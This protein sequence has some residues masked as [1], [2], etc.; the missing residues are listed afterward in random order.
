VEAPPAEA[1]QVPMEPMQA[2]APPEPELSPEE[3]KLKGNEL[4][5]AGRHPEAV[6][7][8]SKAVAADPSSHVFL[9]NRCAANAAMGNWELVQQDATKC[10]EVAQ[11]PFPKGHIHLA[12]ACLRLKDW[13]AGAVAVTAG[14][15]A[16]PEDKELLQLQADLLEGAVTAAKDGQVC[17]GPGVEVLIGLCKSNGND[18]YKAKLY[19]HAVDHY[20]KAI[21]LADK[22]SAEQALLCTLLANRAAAYLMLRECHSCA[23]DC[24]R[25]VAI[26]P[27][28]G[29]LWGRWAS[30]VLALGQLDEALSIL[31]R[32]DSL[33]P[34]LDQAKSVRENVANI[35]RLINEGDEA[36]SGETKSPGKALKCYLDAEERGVT[37]WEKLTLKI[38]RAYLELRQFPRVMNTTQQILKQTGGKHVGALLLRAEAM[39]LNNSHPIDSSAFVEHVDQALKLVTTA[40]SLDPDHEE[41][42]QNRKKLKGVR[43]AVASTKE[44]MTGR[45]FDAARQLLTQALELDSNNKILCARLYAERAKAALRQKDFQAAMKDAA[46]ATYRDHELKDAY[47]TKASAYKGLQKYEEAVRE[48]E[49]L[50]RWCR[51]ETVHQRY[52]E[53]V[54][55]LKKSKRTDLYELLGVSCVASGMEIR[56][57]FREKAAQ[58]HP[59]KW[60]NKTDEEKK[61]AEATFKLLNEAQEILLDPTTKELWDKGYDLEGIKEQVEIRKQRAHRGGGGCCGGG[62]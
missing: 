4:F 42:K 18:K 59:D 24:E 51:D 56:K 38:A 31:D 10:I 1:P 57:G 26:D 30:S 14:L 49:S 54:F 41:A 32:A 45:E 13:S 6:E 36:L 37:A 12:R 34:G 58:W 23:A 25:G 22:W 46:Q 29:K 47:L 50:A 3:M 52:Q 11:V 27:T 60:S 20:G 5:K 53:A 62:C 8:Y 35:Q 2:P 40:L 43:S 48:L 21:M 39:Y 19:S 28:N 61:H 44:K 17:T 7:W 55:E 15:V 16:H 9:S 33:T